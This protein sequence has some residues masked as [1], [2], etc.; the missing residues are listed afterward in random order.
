MIP[1]SFAPRL[2]ARRGIDRPS[3]FNSR[4]LVYS[5]CVSPAASPVSVTYTIDFML[6]FLSPAVVK[7]VRRGWQAAVAGEERRASPSPVESVALAA[8]TRS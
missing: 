7:Y 3:L 2:P 6:V 1:P 4:P 8:N 5:F